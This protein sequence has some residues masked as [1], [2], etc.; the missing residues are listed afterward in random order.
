LGDALWYRNHRKNHVLMIISAPTCCGARTTDTILQ[1]PT[2]VSTMT[3]PDYALIIVRDESRTKKK[4]SPL[5]SE[6]HFEW[7]GVVLQT[8]TAAELNAADGGKS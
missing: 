4:P 6:G 5:L 1:Q 3:E 2:E 7:D 8:Y